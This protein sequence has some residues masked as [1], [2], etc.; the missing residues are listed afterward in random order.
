MKFFKFNEKE[1]K[2]EFNRED[3]LLIDCF[4][5]L[6]KQDKTKDKNKFWSYCRYLYLVY[7]NDSFLVKAKKKLNERIEKSKQYVKIGEND[8]ENPLYKECE[9]EFLYWNYTMSMEIRDGNITTMANID[10]YSKN[11]DL[12]AT[13]KKGELLHDISKIAKS[14]TDLVKLAHETKQLEQMIELELEEKGKARGG[15]S[16]SPHE[17]GMLDKITDKI[18]R[19]EIE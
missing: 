2:I 3:I 6:L 4:N 8:L 5:E 11:A 17:K 9:K 15:K 14:R 12:E 19:G 7:D 13:D 1:N 10:K 16:T 18:I